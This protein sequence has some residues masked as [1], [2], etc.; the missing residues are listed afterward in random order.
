MMAANIDPTANQRPSAAQLSAAVEFGLAP[1]QVDDQV[2]AYLREIRHPLLTQEAEEVLGVAIKAGLQAEKAIAKGDDRPFQRVLA[3]QGVEAQKTLS[4]HNLRLVVSIAKKHVGRG[5][6]LLDLIQEGN[7]GLMRATSK[8]DYKRGFRF[9]TYATWWIRQAI[10]RAIADAGRTI[11]TPVHVGE[12]MNKIRHAQEQLPEGRAQNDYARI[13]ELTGLP[14]AKVRNTMIRAR[15]TG[16]VDSLDAESAMTKRGLND[17]PGATMGELL[18]DPQ[19]DTER[20]GMAA[21][22]AQD[23]AEALATLEPREQEILKI[24]YGLGPDGEHHTLEDTA[25]ILSRTWGGT[26]LTRERI[27]QI[28]SAALRKLRHPSKGARLRRYLE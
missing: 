25:V 10:T 22:L 11:R 2:G 1:D 16:T 20:D 8:F 28:E 13:A 4:A 3:A 24:R 21:M 15:N 7:I 14:E 27:R 26:P 6:H 19:Q 12:T 17:G 23:I 18:A 9:S 5:L